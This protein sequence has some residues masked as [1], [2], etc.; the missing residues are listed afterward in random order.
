V[1]ATA[2]TKEK[3]DWILSIPNGATHAVNYKTQHFSKEVKAITDNKGVDVIVDPVGQNHWEKNLD[4][5]AVD[6]RMII[7]AFM[8]G[9]S[10]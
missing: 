9:A 3:L 5:L 6:G 7:L 2:S 4:S 1:I 8:S 10:P